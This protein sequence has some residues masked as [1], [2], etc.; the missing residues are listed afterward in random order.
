MP[1]LAIIEHG[2]PRLLRPTE[3]VL[4]PAEGEHP[5][6]KVP[7]SAIVLWSSAERLAINVK[8]IVDDPI[9]VRKIATGSTLEDGTEFV[10]RR[11]TLA[12]RPTKEIAFTLLIRR[13]MAENLWDAFSDFMNATAIRRRIWDEMKILRESV[14]PDNIRARQ[15][16]AG[17]SA[18]QEQIDRIMAEP[19]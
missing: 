13:I 5:D 6:R 18:T 3:Y 10:H 19:D 15:L 12:D 8:P 14:P 7:V 4:V 2:Q 11:W 17:I 1:D 9:P 16:L